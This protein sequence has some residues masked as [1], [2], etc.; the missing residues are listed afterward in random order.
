[1]DDVVDGLLAQANQLGTVDESMKLARVT[2]PFDGSHKHSDQYRAFHD[3]SGYAEETI[4]PTEGSL[5]D[6]DMEMMAD[7]GKAEVNDEE[8]AK[9][10]EAADPLSLPS[11]TGDTK[12]QIH[13]CRMII[14]G[15][16]KA[17][18]QSRDHKQL[19]YQ[20]APNA[21]DGKQDQKADNYQ[22]GKTHGKIL[23]LAGEVC[24]R[25]SKVKYELISKTARPRE[26]SGG[27]QSEE[28]GSAE[29]ISLSVLQVA[30]FTHLATGGVL[31]ALANFARFFIALPSADFGHEA[32]FLATFG[33]APESPVEG[34][35]FANFDEWQSGY[36]SFQAD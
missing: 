32:A 15:Q 29:R 26:G 21:G 18:Q 33:K 5:G 19:P 2:D 14:V 27:A 31:L 25:N 22:I 30:H 28:Q 4:E 8:E 7:G 34:F 12:Y 35:A 6:S 10:D 17:Q 11:R 24:R 36:T 20:T 16:S 13:Q 23:D 1:V 9:E 3:T